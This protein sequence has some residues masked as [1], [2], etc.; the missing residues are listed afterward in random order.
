MSREVFAHLDIGEGHATL[1]VMLDDDAVQ[2]GVAFCSPHD[3]YEKKRGRA[4][5]SG[6][7]ASAR[8][9]AFGFPR[10]ADQKLNDQLL[11]AFAAWLQRN[12]DDVPHWV[13][14]K[15]LGIEPA[16]VITARRGPIAALVV[17]AVFRFALVEK[18]PRNSA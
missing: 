12:R 7:R 5:A 10:V 11:G 17:T 13:W 3:N 18:P 2:V 15:V 14:S 6:R 8:R 4:I 1:S 16:T 9:F